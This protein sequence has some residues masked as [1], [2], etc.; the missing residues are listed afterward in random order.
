LISFLQKLGEVIPIYLVIGNHDFNHGSKYLQEVI[1]NQYHNQTLSHF[2]L[3]SANTFLNNKLITPNSFQILKFMTNNNNIKI[4]IFGITTDTTLTSALPSN[5]K[6]VSFISPRKTM[7]NTIKILQKNNV[8]LM[9]AITHLG[10]NPNNRTYI[11]S[12]ELLWNQSKF[13]P[14]LIVD[15]HLHGYQITDQKFSPFLIRSQ[16]YGQQ[17]Q[18]IIFTFNKN[19]MKNIHIHSYDFM[20]YNRNKYFK[21]I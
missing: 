21:F 6:N 1:F 13:K 18:V 10:I 7:S 11:G 3:L 5:I 8:D 15:G 20:T 17:V 12:S 14:H 16:G 2:R 9:I 4:G 19:L